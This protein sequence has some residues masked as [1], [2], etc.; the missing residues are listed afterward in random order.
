ML[1]CTTECWASCCLV[2]K[3]FWHTSH[4]WERSAL[5]FPYSFTAPNQRHT[6]TGH[7]GSAGQEKGVGGGAGG[8]WEWK[9]F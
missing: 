2:K 6:T 4:T 1:V 7:E 5:S 8:V 3:P 9:E